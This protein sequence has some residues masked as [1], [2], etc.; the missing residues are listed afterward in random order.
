MILNIKYIK[1]VIK[2]KWFVFLEACKLGVPLLGIV[3]DMSK[4][5]PDEFIP[6]AKYDFSEFGKNEK[7]VQE[8]FDLA[9]LKH[10]RRNKHHWQYWLLINDSG[11]AGKRY[12]SN[13]SPAVFVKQVEPL[14][15]PERYIREMIADWKGAGRAYGNSDTRGWYENNKSKIILH[16]ETEKAVKVLLEIY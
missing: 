4:I 6:Y 11:W 7:S 10:Q 9:W 8:P 12:K 2:H 14:P 15:M 3:H 13:L 16:P 1:S 5:L